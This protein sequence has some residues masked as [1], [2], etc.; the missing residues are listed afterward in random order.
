MLE[1]ETPYILINNY[2]LENW[3]VSYTTDNLSQIETQNWQICQI[4]VN[5]VNIVLFAKT[6]K[7]GIEIIKEKIQMAKIQYWSQKLRSLTK[8]VSS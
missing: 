1:K 2:I 6:S 8:A 7:E 3:Y 4:Y 5:V